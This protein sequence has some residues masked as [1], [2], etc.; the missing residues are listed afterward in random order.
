MHIYIIITHTYMSYVYACISQII[1][2]L[3]FVCL[4][5]FFLILNY[6]TKSDILGYND[7]KVMG[8]YVLSCLSGTFMLIMG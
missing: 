2:L 4:L 1:D 7:G 8:R 6:L 3:I 5:T